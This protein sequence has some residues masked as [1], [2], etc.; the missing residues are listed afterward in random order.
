[1]G[2]VKENL[3]DLVIYWNEGNAEGEMEGLALINTIIMFF[4]WEIQTK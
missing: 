2:N 1:M 3:Q 4:N